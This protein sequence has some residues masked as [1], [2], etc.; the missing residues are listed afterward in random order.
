M[1][2]LSDFIDEPPD[3]GSLEFSVSVAP[4]SL[5]ANSD[6]KRKLKEEI[7]RLVQPVKYLLTGEVQVDIEWWIHERER[8]ETSS[9]PDVDNVIKPLLDAI[10]GPSGLLIDDSQVQAVSCYWVDWNSRSQMIKYR[11]RFMP[12]LY[13]KKEGLRFVHVSDDLCFPL[14][15]VFPPA[16]SSKYIE[17]V[18]KAFE[19]NKQFLDLGADYYDARGVMPIQRLFH[20]GRLHEFE[21]VEIS[22]TILKK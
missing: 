5:Q 15:G 6:K 19:A 20:R 10:S 22:D 7:R 16:V 4:V 3:Y 11:L 17:C 2:N 9:S 14:P 8:Y 1:A 21:I 18:Q 13:I 12:D